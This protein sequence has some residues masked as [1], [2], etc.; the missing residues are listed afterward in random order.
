MSQIE[1]LAALRRFHA[2]F[3]RKGSWGGSEHAIEAAKQQGSTLWH[4]WRLAK[5]ARP[6]EPIA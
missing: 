3:D 1:E 2:L 4:A 5:D 6:K